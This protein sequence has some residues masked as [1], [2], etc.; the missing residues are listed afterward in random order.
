VDEIKRDLTEIKVDIADIKAD[1]RNHIRRTELNETAISIME[2]AIYRAQ[3]AIIFIG[4]I[5]TI[6]SIVGVYLR[7][8]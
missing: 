1:L 5:S 6:A 7:L 4:V 2:K 3:G 8:K